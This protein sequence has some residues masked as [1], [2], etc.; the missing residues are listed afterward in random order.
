MTPYAKPEALAKSIKLE[1]WKILDLE[2][3][4]VAVPDAF[5]MKRLRHKAYA[6][7][8]RQRCLH[9]KRYLTQLHGALKLEEYRILI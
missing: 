1:L 9:A 7:Y 2:F 6:A 4:E 8:G 5:E 3:P